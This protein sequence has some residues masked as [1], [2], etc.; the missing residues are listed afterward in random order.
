MR[1][2]A[3][4]LFLGSLRYTVMQIGIFCFKR[5][6]G[7]CNIRRSRVSCLKHWETTVYTTFYSK[8]KHIYEEDFSKKV[9]EIIEF[10]YNA[11]FDT[12]TIIIFLKEILALKVS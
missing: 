8:S 12:I 11:S 7:G 1:I 10:F 2:Q 5:G 6:L 9:Q 3:Y 4:F